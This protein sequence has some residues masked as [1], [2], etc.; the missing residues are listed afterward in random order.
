MPRVYL[1][2]VCLEDQ[3]VNPLFAFLKARLTLAS[4]GKAEIVMPVGMHLRQGGGVVAG[5]I[6]A[7][8]ADEAMAHAVMSLL[9][10]GR[11]TVTAEMNIRYLRSLDPSQGGAMRAAARVIKSG[12]SLCFAEAEVRDLTD[13][14]L[15]TAGA[16]F[17]VLKK[18]RD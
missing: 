5:G 8:L 9:E 17:Y 1:E 6:M 16:T 11:T 2:A 15:A 7:T 4:E 12:Q 10:A 13:R 3:C 14:L 18:K